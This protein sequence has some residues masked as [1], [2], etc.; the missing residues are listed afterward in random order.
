MMSMNKTTETS[1]GP[2]L[3]LDDRLR[4]QMLAFA[5]LQLGN[6][7]SLAEDAVHEAMLAAWQGLTDFRG[8][9][10]VKTWVFGI[11]RH[12][13]V[14]ILRSR[15]RELLASELPSLS[16][17]ASQQEA[18]PDMAERVFNHRGA[19]LRENRPRRCQDDPLQAVEDAGFWTVFNT[20]LNHLPGQQ[21]RLFMMRE[22]LGLSGPEICEL[23]AISTS[24]LHVQLYRARL[25]LR[26]CLHRNWFEEHKK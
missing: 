11:L 26:S 9:S 1:T 7:Q 17:E 24:N 25:Q 22:Y 13:I 8:R 15:G 16:A 3:G 20:C 21:A 14:D 12:K 10:S 5:R 18:D 2:E 6:N 4:E 23:L 19:W